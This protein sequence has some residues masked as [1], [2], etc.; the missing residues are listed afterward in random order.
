MISEIKNARP[1][2]ES[3]SPD[4]IGRRRAFVIDAKGNR[5]VWNC[6]WFIVDKNGRP[7]P[8]RAKRRVRFIHYY[9]KPVTWAQGIA[10]CSSSISKQRPDIRQQP[11]SHLEFRKN[12]TILKANTPKAKEVLHGMDKPGRAWRRFVD[13]D[14]WTHDLFGSCYL[15]ATDGC[16]AVIETVDGDHEYVCFENL[17]EN[18]GVPL[19]P[20][21]AKAKP[22]TKKREKVVSSLLAKYMTKIN[23]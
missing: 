13:R 9:E 15:L 10:E 18:L 21:G 14:S 17:S 19:P 5:W 23:K 16:H 1:V 12:V 20:R 2:G 7:L 4:M 6:G 22:T 8:T 11:M 3:L